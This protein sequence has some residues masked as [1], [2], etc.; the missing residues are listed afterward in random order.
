MGIFYAV[1]VIILFVS[2]LLIK[3]TEKKID[4]LIQVALAFVLLF[5]YNTFICYIL[6]FFTIPITLLDLACINLV[7]S[8]I[9]IIYMIKTKKIQSYSIKKID[10]LYIFILAVGVIVVSYINFGFPIEIKYETGDPSV[11][12]LT[13]EMFAEGD[14]LLAA[15]D[16]DAVYGKFTTRKIASY[17][18]S[19]LIMKCFQ[20]VIDSFDNYIIFVLFGMFVLFLTAW[21]FYSTIVRFAKNNITRFLAFIVALLYTMGYPLNSFLFGFEYL[22]MG[23]LILGAIIAC[24]DIY[25]NEEISFK[26]NLLVFFLLNFGLFVAYYMLVP[27]VYSALWIYFMLT[28]RKRQ[29]KWITLKTVLMLTITLLI[30]FALGYIYTIAPDIYGIFISN[31]S[32]LSNAMIYSGSLVNRGLS[33]SGYIYVNLFSNVLP[34]LP[35]AIFA[36]YKNWNENKAVGL[37]A[38]FDIGF[39]TLLLIGQLLGKVSAY[40]LSKNYYAL[41]LLL[42]YLNYKGIIISYEKKKWVSC[43]CIGGYIVAIIINLLFYNE[44][45]PH[46]KIDTDENIF[47]V[48]DIYGANKTILKNTKDLTQSELELLKYVRDN[49]PEDKII[50]IA[51]DTEQGYWGYAILRIIND[52]DEHGGESKLT[53]KMIKV[54]LKAGKVDYILYFNRGVFYQVWKEILWENAELVYENEVGGILQ[55]KK[56]E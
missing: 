23:I 42:Y 13:S 56:N 16:A 10:L 31:N 30:P 18:N 9:M 43:V 21:L 35:F 49:I 34:L 4:I 25:H 26:H 15:E 28:E 19:G 44:S 33:V 48:V 50:E 7:F 14:S 51:G 39:I 5:C 40:Y 41:W 55:Y 20:G 1:S 22:S 8:T 12:Y 3:K 37:M 36:M 45:I 53:W 38:L 6:T 29:N 47:Q 46:G 2:Y 54:G 11:H 52:D 27:Y 17:V 32:D 24:V